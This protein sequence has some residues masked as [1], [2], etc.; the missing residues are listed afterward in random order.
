MANLRTRF[1]EYLPFGL[2]AGIFLIPSRDRN[3]P[4]EP[5]RHTATAGSPHRCGPQDDARRCNWVAIGAA[6]I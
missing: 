3:S 5:V 6:L 2:E 1:D 4:P